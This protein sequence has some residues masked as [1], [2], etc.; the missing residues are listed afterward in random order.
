MFN[1]D[2]IMGFVEVIETGS[3]EKLQE[4]IDAEGLPINDKWKDYDLL[5]YALA[6]GQKE[7]AMMLIERGCR[8]NNRDFAL[9][10]DTPLH[11]AIKFGSIEIVELLLRKGASIE[12]RNSEGETPLHLSAKMRNNVFT[13]LLLTSL[14]NTTD[15]NYVDSSGLTYLH[16]ACMRDNL[17]LI[18]RLL[19]NHCEINHCINFDSPELPG[20]TALH[21]AI[22]FYNLDAI[23]LLLSHKASISVKAKNGVTPLHLAVKYGVLKYVK[24]LLRHSSNIN[25]D[26]NA[27]IDVDTEEY[28]GY[29]LLH[30]AIDLNWMS[31]FNLLMR[32]KPNADTKS[33]T[34]LTPL[35]IALKENA[36]DVVN[37]LLSYGVEV[38]CVEH[39]NNTTPLHLATLNKQL[40]II[41]TLVKRGAKVSAQQRDGLTPL[42]I[43]A[44][45]KY[46]RE[47]KTMHSTLLDLPFMFMHDEVMNESQVTPQTSYVFELLLSATDLFDANPVDSRGLSHFH[48]V[49]MCLGKDKVL[50]YLQKNARVKDGINDKVSEDSPVWPGYT[51]LHFA[52]ENGKLDVVKVL[53]EYKADVRAVNAKGMTP[54]H[55]ADQLIDNQRK[56]YILEELLDTLYKDIADCEFPNKNRGMTML[57]VTCMQKDGKVDDEDLDDME[58][59]EA[60]IDDDSPIWPGCTPLHLAAIFRRHK[61]ID[62]LLLCD[63]DPNVED[64]RGL[65]P[66]HIACLHNDEETISK[67]LKAEA[68]VNHAVRK[69]SEYAG[70]TA[71]HIA[72]N[73]KQPSI[74]VVRKLLRRGANINA[75]DLNSDTP[76]TLFANWY[77]NDTLFPPL[78]SAYP[79]SFELTEFAMTL[80]A[81]DFRFNEA[82]TKAFQ[83]INDWING[84]NI[85]INGV[86][87]VEIKNKNHTNDCRAE[88]KKLKSI[89]IDKSCTLYD[90]LLKNTDEMANRV[91]NT[92]F[93]KILSSAIDTDFPIYGF[94]LKV[95]YRSGIKRRNYLNF[96]KEA[97]AE[98]IPKIPLPD[99]CSE[100]IFKYL[101]NADLDN[102]IKANEVGYVNYN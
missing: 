69:S 84:T 49:C 30:F 66:L 54:I 18:E 57:H 20:Y 90:L 34:G 33:K 48:I 32:Y 43:A 92:I 72:L 24:M 76:I 40:G 39:E 21:C 58:N 16:I 4:L 12:A 19:Q 56:E 53:L 75:M 68:D 59:I 81:I 38:N 96:A 27:Q 42:L 14:S 79:I 1:E 78:L 101:S 86:S 41:R 37:E 10:A 62:S 70:K 94:L 63:A 51:A 23:Q 13:D 100:S 17:T 64:A 85:F 82:T 26:I 5:N 36:I 25:L 47:R 50:G 65:T 60:T 83:K 29:S 91:K 22:E 95:Q 45:W 6:K 77:S 35:H 80:K 89:R 93:K 2:F 88:I 71:L 44:S 8:V 52:V 9:P 102:L 99:S 74:N 15:M 87:L 11:H 46:E 55:L 61:V 3:T 97:L 31:I 98:L 67:L 73:Q 28:P 7:A